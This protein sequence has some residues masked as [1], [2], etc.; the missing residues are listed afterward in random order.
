VRVGVRA[1][2]RCIGAFAAR[3][4]RLDRDPALVNSRTRLESY[5][6]RRHGTLTGRTEIEPDPPPR[7]FAP[8]Y[9]RARPGYAGMKSGH[10]VARGRLA[11]TRDAGGG[12]TI[13]ARAGKTAARGWWFC[14]RRVRKRRGNCEKEER[15]PLGFVVETGEGASERRARQWRFHA[16][17]TTRWP[18]W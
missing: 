13:Q 8:G 4:G 16:H 6:K 5:R 9:H 7:V 17:R 18:H 3:V 15:C 10:A 1:R 11:R 12:T 2:N 14:R